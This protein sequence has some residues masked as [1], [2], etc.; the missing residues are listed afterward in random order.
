VAE[1][2]LESTPAVLPFYQAC[3]GLE[4]ALALGVERLRA[5]SLMQQAILIDRLSE[6]GVAILG[7]GLPR[8]A[9]VAIP[10]SKAEAAAAR[11]HAKSV[12]ADARGDLLRTCPDILNS[13]EEL[14]EAANRVA[15]V[16]RSS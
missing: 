15:H 5:Y 13:S 16:L 2:W 12:V 6:Q 9:F 4:F 3:A 14:A 8:G 7:G 1:G 11:L 10:A